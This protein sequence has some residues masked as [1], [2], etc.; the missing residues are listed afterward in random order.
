MYSHEPLQPL[1]SLSNLIKGENKKKH[2][3][4]NSI[5]VKEISTIKHNILIHM[6]PIHKLN[7]PTDNEWV[8][9]A[10]YYWDQ[11]HRKI[12]Q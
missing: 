2:T 1:S 9:M 10:T 3:Q 12:L 7:F 6:L 8:N 11:E 4:Q 5:Q